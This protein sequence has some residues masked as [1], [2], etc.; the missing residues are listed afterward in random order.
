MAVAWVVVAVFFGIVEVTSAAFYAAFLALG[1]LAA[2]VAAA[3]GADVIVQAIVFLLVAV[4][5]IVFVRPFVTRMR[6]PMLVSG[7]EAM[8]GQEAI[9]VDPIEGAH[10]PGH[11]KIA[12]ERWLAESVDGSPVPEGATVKIAEIRG[13]TLLVH[14]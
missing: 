1:A 6:G 12:G 13:L 9:V 10:Q 5:G 2:A 8:I 4:L 7:A 3:L 14:K 11:V